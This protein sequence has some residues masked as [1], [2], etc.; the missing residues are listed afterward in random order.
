MKK[1]SIIVPVYNTE[2]YLDK[3]INSLINQ[4]LKDI[5]IIFVNDGSTDNSRNII[6]KYLTDKRIILIDKENG[7]QASARNLGIK[8]SNGIYIMFIDSDDY[9]NEDMCEKIYNIASSGNYDIVSV[10]YFNTTDRIDSYKKTFDFS[11][12]KISALEYLFSGVGPCNKMFKA[13]FLKENNFSFPENIIYEDFASIP[14]LAKYNPNCYYLSEAFMHY[15]HHEGSTMINKE[16]K[17]KYEDIFAASNYL[18]D[19]LND[20]GYNK[21]LEYLLIYH[22]LYLGSLNFYKYNKLDQI[23]R[24]SLF[25]KEKFPK[26][27]KN[28]YLKKHTFKEKLLMRLFYLRMYNVIKFFQKIKR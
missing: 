14:T 1:I 22:L 3:C 20:F 16:Y 26:W 23:N 25:M 24:I 9:V 13:S 15:V 12:R 18:Y 6:E 5:E 8:K 11:S 21:Q 7:G 17:K 10:D 27:R 4:T 28:E 19:N 2:K